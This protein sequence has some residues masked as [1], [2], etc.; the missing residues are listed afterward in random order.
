MLLRESSHLEPSHEPRVVVHALE[1]PRR[2]ETVDA[3]VSSALEPVED[4]ESVVAAREAFLAG[5]PRIDLGRE[6]GGV[7]PG[8]RLLVAALHT[9]PRD[10][11]FG[12]TLESIGMRVKVGFDV[13]SNRR[14]DVGLRVASEQAG[15]DR[16]VPSVVKK[17]PGVGGLGIVDDL[18]VLDPDALVEGYG[19][20]LAGLDLEADLLDPSS[21]LAK[22]AAVGLREG[23]LHGFVLDHHVVS[24]TVFGE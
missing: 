19:E 5:Q 18:P 9:T 8:D 7:G 15:N 12:V 21:G 24:V 22:E 3:D 2:T 11:I 6:S 20:T 4:V 16:Q 10:R 23:G 17:V 13:G 1:E 14:D